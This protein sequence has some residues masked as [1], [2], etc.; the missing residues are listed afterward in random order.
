M[1]SNA[2]MPLKIDGSRSAAMIRVAPPIELSGGKH[3]ARPDVG[4]D[5]ASGGQRV[6]AE[7]VPAH[8]PVVGHD[9]VAVAAVVVCPH[10]EATLESLRDG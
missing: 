9:R 7:G 4:R 2:T 3:L 10:V 6:V 8:G 5:V 1:G